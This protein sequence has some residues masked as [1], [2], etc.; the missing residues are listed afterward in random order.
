MEVLIDRGSVRNLTKRKF[1]KNS[2]EESSLNDTKSLFDP[3]KIISA[4]TE[5]KAQKYKKQSF[6]VA[7]EKKGYYNRII[8]EKKKREY[9]DAAI[10]AAK[11][12]ML[13]AEEAGYLEAEGL[14]KTFKVTQKQ[15]IP[16]LPISAASKSF[17]LKL[18]H[19]GPYSIDYTR[20]GRHLLIGGRKGHVA[21][22]DWRAG[23]LSCELQLKETIRDVKYLHNQTMFAVAQKK[24]TYIYDNSGAEVHCLKKLREVSKLDFLPYHYLLTS[25]SNSG[26]L[27]YLDVSTGLMVSEIH[28]K[29][30]ST[31]AFVHNPQNAVVHMGHSKGTVTLWS[32]SSKEPLVKMLCHQGP[33]RSISVDQTGNYLASA[34]MDGK[35][36]VWDLRQYK[37]LYEYFT[38][39]P[40]S[41]ISFSQRGILGVAFTGNI[42]FWRDICSTKQNSPYMNHKASPHQI[43]DISFCPYEDVLGFGHSG[44]F[45]SVVI[46][47]AGEPNF[48]TLEVNPYETLKQ[49]REHEVHSLLSKIQPDSIALDSNI[50]GS[51]VE[52][53]EYPEEEQLTTSTGK[54][55]EIKHKARGKSSSKNRFERKKGLQELE[56]KKE[57]SNDLVSKFSAKKAKKN[58]K[59]LPPQAPAILPGSALNRFRNNP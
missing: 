47:G 41:S 13:L 56:R 8:V 32:P 21:S 29:L 24:Y 12:E 52:N 18:D 35:L 42:S 54:T 37:L 45:S 40:A 34:G 4:D 10:L 7:K 33:V 3:T 31:N 6:D 36:K 11:S 25:I 48:D 14:E 23:K 51:I 2:S 17:E 59:L 5:E 39:R 57:R 46:P 16:N 30:G 38:P 9:E 55:I 1:N 44:G 43:H 26:I 22:F 20:N 15:L 28:T 53:A 58:K 50:I 49:R 19:F 27:S